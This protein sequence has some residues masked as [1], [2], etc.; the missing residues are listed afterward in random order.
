MDSDDYSTEDFTRKRENDPE[1]KK[2]DILNV[3]TIKIRELQEEQREYRNEMH[4]HKDKN[5]NQKQKNRETKQKVE[6]L[7]NK[8]DRTK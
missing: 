3:L 6:E 8:I 7:K 5:E 1:D 2:C 4:K